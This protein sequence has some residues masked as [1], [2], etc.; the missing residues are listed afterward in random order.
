[1]LKA[2]SHAESKYVLSNQMFLSIVILA[3]S[4]VCARLLDMNVILS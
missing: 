4:V 2:P 1:M 3:C